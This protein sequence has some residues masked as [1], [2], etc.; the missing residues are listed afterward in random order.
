MFCGAVFSAMVSRFTS[1]AYEN[2]RRRTGQRVGKFLADFGAILVLSECSC[3]SP[4]EVNRTRF[5]VVVQYH[6][7][8]ALT[9]SLA[10]QFSG[11][12]VVGEI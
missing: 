3:P 11:S 9:Q 7:G 8:A 10:R 6:S 5:G 2:M 1:R 4:R 12:I